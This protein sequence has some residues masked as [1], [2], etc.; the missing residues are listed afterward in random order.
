MVQSGILTSFPPK[1]QSGSQ[2]IGEPCEEC[3]YEHPKEMQASSADEGK[4]THSLAWMPISELN[5]L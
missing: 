5:D 4:E 1:I 2:D 3:K